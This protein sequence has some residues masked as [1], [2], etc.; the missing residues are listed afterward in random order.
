MAL[1]QLFRQGGH[2]AADGPLAPKRPH[3]APRAKNVI[4]LFMAGGP[5]HLELFDFKPKLA[6]FDGTPPP[7]ELIE[8]YRAA[9]INPNAKLM[10]PKFKFSRHG[11][12]G[13]EISELLPYTAQVAEGDPDSLA[14]WPFVRQHSP[15]CTSKTVTARHAASMEAQWSGGSDGRPPSGLRPGPRRKCRRSRGAPPLCLPKAERLRLPGA[16]R[17]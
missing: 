4:Y 16:R 13:A 7:A 3:H 8:G 6:E 10:G 1:G 9:F 14:A 17:P 15:Q 2:A 11:E 12:S 5:S